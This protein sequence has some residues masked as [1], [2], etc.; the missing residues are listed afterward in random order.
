MKGFISRTALAS[1]LTAGLAALGGGC[2][3]YYDVVDPCYPQRYNF[4]ARKEVCEARYQQVH[5]GHVLDQTM[6]NWQFE[7]GTDKLND[8][9]KDH[10]IYLLRRR[11]CPD[12]C[13]YLATA[14]DVH[15]CFGNGHSDLVYD[16]EHPEKFAEARADLDARRVVAIQ[17][18]LTAQTAGRGLA[19]HVV[20]HD[21]AEANSLASRMGVSLQLRDA[22]TTGVQGFLP[23]SSAGTGGTAGA[24]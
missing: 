1:C 16:P 21:P 9:G 12:Q 23:P 3:G 15:E 5:N 11:P 8:A 14:E 22:P 19:F 2:C 18:Y 10:L 17:K 24:R 20:V 7:P 6:W 13:I 4:A